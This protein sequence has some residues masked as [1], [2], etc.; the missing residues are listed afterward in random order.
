MNHVIT[1]G[2]QF[3]SGGHE[4]GRR[5]SAK[6][7]IPFYDKELLTLTAEDSIKREVYGMTKVDCNHSL[8]VYG[9]YQNNDKNIFYILME[10]CDGNIEKLVKD[11]GYPL[12]VDEIL[13]LLKQLNIFSTIIE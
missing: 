8:K 11:R 6:Y 13:I 7:G 2:R 9:V 1:I 12:N 3:G 5:L 10:Q 4:V